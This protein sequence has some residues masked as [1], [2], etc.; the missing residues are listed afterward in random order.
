[1]M[2]TLAFAAAVFAL[3]LCSAGI[4][5]AGA[6]PPSA[7]PAA[8][9]PH[10]YAALPQATARNRRVHAWPAVPNE[11]YHLLYAFKGYP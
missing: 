2:R 10:A 6:L 11:S 4:D 8:A 7:V 1:M 9:L 3:V 5:N